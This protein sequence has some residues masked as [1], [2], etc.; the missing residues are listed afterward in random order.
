MGWGFVMTHR[1]FLTWQEWLAEQWNT[2]S[3]TD[4]YLMRVALRCHQAALHGSSEAAKVTE[5]DQRVRFTRQRRKRKEEG[6]QEHTTESPAIKPLSQETK[7]AITKSEWRRR[8]GGAPISS[9]PPPKE[10]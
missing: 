8:M 9:T 4:H 10:K 2:P 3:R 5:D 7:V 6:G 1:Q